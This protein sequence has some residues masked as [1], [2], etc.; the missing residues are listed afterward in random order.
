MCEDVKQ[1]GFSCIADGSATWYNHFGN[2]EVLSHKVKLMLTY[3]SQNY[4]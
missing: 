2:Q 1:R 4:S 3:D